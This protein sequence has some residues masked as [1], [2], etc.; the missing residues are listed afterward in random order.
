MSN[1]IAAVAVAVAL[2]AKLYDISFRSKTYTFFLQCAAAKRSATSRVFRS[3]AQ[4]T[5]AGLDRRRRSIFFL[6]GASLADLFSPQAFLLLLGENH[7]IDT[8]TQTYA[9]FLAHR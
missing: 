1:L 4:Q 9:S 5:G 8:L 7:T 3:V 2:T 6:K